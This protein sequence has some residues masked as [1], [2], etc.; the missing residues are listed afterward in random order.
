MTTSLAFNDATTLSPKAQ[1]EQD[2]DL[3]MHAA[4]EY[5][6]KAEYSDAR[7]LYEIVLNS[8]DDHVDANYHLGVLHMQTG[9]PANAVPLFERVL[10][11]TPNFAQ[12]WVYYF[13]ALVGSNQFEAARA[14]LFLAQEYGVPV[15][16]INA[17][18]AQLP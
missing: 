1:R 16:A 12:L 7:T 4:I 8:D 10:G 11:H 14:S 6:R 5:H 15:E 13:N 2:I 17:L 3:V 18:R 9:D